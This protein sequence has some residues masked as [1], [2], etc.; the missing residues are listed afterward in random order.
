MAFLRSLGN[1][2]RDYIDWGITLGIAIV[3]VALSIRGHI[4]SSVLGATTLLV[5]SA[6][7]ISAIRD[8]ANALHL[9]EQLN[10]LSKAVS[11]VTEH[12]AL[13]TDSLQTGIERV[14]PQTAGYDWI[15]EIKPARDI[16]IAKLRLNITESQQYF[17]ALEQVLISGGSVSLVMA[18]P[19]SP[20]MWLRYMDEPHKASGRGGSETAW[21]SGLQKLA[22]E[23]LQLAAWRERL[24]QAGSDPTRLYLGVF[25]HYPTHAFYKF[26]DRLY[27]YHYPYMQRGFHGPAFL[28]TDKETEVHRY[29][30]RCLIS[31]VHESTPID[32]VVEDVADKYKKGQF[33]DL[34]VEKLTVRLVRKQQE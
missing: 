22:E 14:L 4:S 20:A 7:A 12:E 25:A 6:L 18:D 16:T 5:L 3:V 19:R 8:R 28:F 11:V 17:S 10:G 27:V 24:L 1:L 15:R 29:L 26:D 32:I 31:V 21:I 34:S 33:S 23:L 30:T 9:Q 13:L 2:L